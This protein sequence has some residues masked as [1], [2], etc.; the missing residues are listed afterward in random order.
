[1]GS[2]P[3]IPMEFAHRPLINPAFGVSCIF[4][5]LIS[6]R[7]LRYFTFISGGDTYS[8]KK[9]DPRHITKTIKNAGIK[10]YSCLFIGDSKYDLQCSDNAN[11][12]CILLSHGY[13][14][15]DIKKLG[16]YRVVNNL[17]DAMS[18]IEKYF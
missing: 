2:I 5:Y 17:K 18:E 11:I 3:P 1:M 9:P 15:V 8:F 6:C 13:S 4:L 16:A 12:H 7:S 10:S 14:N